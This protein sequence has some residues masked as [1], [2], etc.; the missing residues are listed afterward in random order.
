MNFTIMNFYN[1]PVQPNYGSY[2]YSDQPTVWRLASLHEHASWL[3]SILMHFFM[4]SS[5]LRCTC[6]KQI[7]E[8]KPTSYHRL[9]L[10]CVFVFRSPHPIRTARQVVPPE[11]WGSGR[12]CCNLLDPLPAKTD[13]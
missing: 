3:I 5:P 2:C 1:V 7:Y 13:M 12:S 4:L 11:I 9:V 8:I 10:R 6:N